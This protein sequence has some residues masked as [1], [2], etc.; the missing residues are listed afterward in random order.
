MLKKVLIANRGEIAVRIIRACKELNIKTVAIYSTED[1]NALHV[2]L[3]DE[4]IC[5]GF[6]KSNESYLNINNILTAAIN[7]NC[8][9]IH[10]GYGFL[11]ENYKFAEEVEKL[12]IKFIGPSSKVIK[13]MGDK[14]KAKEIMQKNNVPTVPGSIGVIKDAKEAMSIAKDIGLPVL[15]KAAG[16]GGGR[17]MRRVY[18]IKNVENEFREARKEAISVFNNGDM[19]IEKLIENP[20]HV[21]IQILADSYGNVISLG[22]R[23][24]SIQRKNQKMI[25]ESPCPSINENLRE[26]MSKNAILAAKACNY[27]NAGTIEFVLDKDKFYFIEMN[28]RLQ[29][30]HPVTEMVSGVDIV[31]EQLKIASKMPLCIKEN[32]KIRNHSIECRIN[33]ENPFKNFMPEA[34]KVEFL[35]VPGGKNVRFD[36][37]LYSGCKISPYYDSMVGK[38]IVCDKTRAGAIKKLRTAI[39]ELV[40]DGVM[41]NSILQYSILFNDEFIRGDYNTSFIEKNLDTLL[42]SLDLNVGD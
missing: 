20:K 14:I 34:G 40:V 5:V 1:K 39:E 28:T 42:L 9:G 36:T 8:D 23:D 10:P 30:E 25:E 29:V 18:D 38:L 19:Y 13:T 24:C 4:A 6:S 32:V 33:A 17:G 22:E 16:G 2:K 35:N 26:E 41:T 27:E 7:L 21:E 3:A 11:S 37:Y 12:N 31:K 15:I